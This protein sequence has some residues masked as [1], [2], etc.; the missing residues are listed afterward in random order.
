MTGIAGPGIGRHG[1]TVE[2]RE[3]SPWIGRHG[4]SMTGIAGPW[5]GR[6]GRTV[7]SREPSP[8]IGRHGRTVESREPS[9]GIG[10]HGRSM[11]DKDKRC[12]SQNHGK[13]ECA[14]KKS[15]H[16]LGN[17]FFELA[18]ALIGRV[19]ERLE[20]RTNTRGLPSTLIGKRLAR[21]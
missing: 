3:S 18:R 8:W 12:Q 14:L 20:E 1:R 6:H 5:I 10:R 15:A 13:W 7:E 11:T 9:P 16:F 21:V 4:R 17:S 19:A 2:S